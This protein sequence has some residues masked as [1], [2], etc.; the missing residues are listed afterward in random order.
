MFDQLRDS[1]RHLSS[2][3]APEER[4]RAASGMRE[5]M[6]HAKLGLQDLRDS[7]RTTEARVASERKELETVQRRLR[8]AREV[9]DEETV[10]V[11]ER[12]EKQ[13]AERMA[14]LEMKLM[15]QQQELTVTERELEEMSQQFRLAM[16]G[17]APGGS[18]PAAAAQ[19]EVDALLNED[20]AG[21]QPS[22]VSS[23]I[24]GSSLPR[25]SRAEREADAED[26]LAALKRRMGK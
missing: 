17:I 18:D 1:L 8:L 3:L 16:S 13:H 19:R 12:F 25:R 11:A 7:L 9:N 26:R 22:G 21:A 24:D 2:I 14:M 23:D 6:I 10:R 20:E 15:S 4:R 5:A